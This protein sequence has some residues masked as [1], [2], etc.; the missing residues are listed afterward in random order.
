MHGVPRRGRERDCHKIELLLSPTAVDEPRWRL[1]PCPERLSSGCR[2]PALRRR[3]PTAAIGVG[4]PNRR[5]TAVRP[6]DGSSL[7]PTPTSTAAG[8]RRYRD[9]ITA[10]G[11]TG[12][13]SPHHESLRAVAWDIDGTLTDSEP[14]QERVLPRRRPA[15]L[16]DL[17]LDAVSRRP[18]D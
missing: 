1:S 13:S 16:S 7:S 4:L 5:W 11:L 6:A 12:P 18:R 8:Y 14:L 10:A 17:E 3:L 2:H 15:D 9:L